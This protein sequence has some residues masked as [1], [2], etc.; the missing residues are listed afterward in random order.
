MWNRLA[1][2]GLV[3]V[4]GAGNLCSGSRRFRWLRLVVDHHVVIVVAAEDA[5]DVVVAVLHRHDAHGS[6]DGGAFSC[7]DRGHTRTH[8]VVPLCPL[9]RVG[10]VWEH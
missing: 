1:F 10:E 5:R 4:V 3:G 9:S 7:K 8:A 6:G 2:R